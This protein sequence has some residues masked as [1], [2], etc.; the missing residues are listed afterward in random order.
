LSNNKG[1]ISLSPFALTLKR[2]CTIKAH[3]EY[4]TQYRKQYMVIQDIKLANIRHCHGKNL[5]TRRK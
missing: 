3:A 5:W 1:I 2:Y 4:Q